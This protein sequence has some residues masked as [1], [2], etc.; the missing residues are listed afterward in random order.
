MIKIDRQTGLNSH[1][2]SRI[3]RIVPSDKAFYFFTSIGNYTGTNAS[4]LGD[5]A[6]KIREVDIKSLEFHIKRGDFEKWIAQT[7]E[8]NVLAR[9]VKQLEESD[10][11]GIPLRDRLYSAIS[12]RCKMLTEPKSEQITKKKPQVKVRSELE[13]PHQTKEA[14]V[15]NT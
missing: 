14:Q 13:L 8:D 7:L 5:F 11:R 4:S 12:N 15:S 2:I 9:R 6:K 3:L 1:Q 10:L